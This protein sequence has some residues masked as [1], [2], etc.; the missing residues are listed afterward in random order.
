MAQVMA[1]RQRIAC[2]SDWFHRRTGTVGYIGRYTLDQAAI[3]PRVENEPPSETI[4]LAKES[5]YPAATLTWGIF[6]MDSTLANLTYLDSE[7]VTYEETRR[8]PSDGAETVEKLAL[9]RTIAPRRWEWDPD[10]QIVRE[11]RGRGGDYSVHQ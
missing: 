3:R 1:M 4:R 7:I 11:L 6:V 5:G 10:R 8:E 9:M 2:T